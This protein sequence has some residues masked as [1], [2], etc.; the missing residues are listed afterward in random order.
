MRHRRLGFR[1]LGA[2]VLAGCVQN[3]TL[4]SQTV[5]VDPPA[6][7]TDVA[8]TPA[9]A[10]PANQ[11]VYAL[12][13]KEAQTL[14]YIKVAPGLNLTGSVLGPERLVANGAAGLIAN[15]AAGLIA[16]GAAGLIANGAA[17]LIANGAAGLIANGAAGRQTSNNQVTLDYPVADGWVALS[18]PQG[19][20]LARPDG[21]PYGGLTD[22]SGSFTLEAPAGQMVVTV[23][24]EGNRRLSA[25]VVNDR[26]DGKIAVDLGTTL[27]TEYLRSRT[28]RIGKDL[29]RVFA[30]DV[31]LVQY[32]EL[33]AQ[34][35]A[36]LRNNDLAGLTAA[37]LGLDAT[38]SMLHRYALAVGRDNS[39]LLGKAWVA[40][41]KRILGEQAPVEELMLQPLA[42]D[43]SALE[44]PVSETSRVLAFDRDAGRMYLNSYGF[45]T[46]SLIALDA[47]ATASRVV[48]RRY[49]FAANGMYDVQAIL[50]D[51]QKDSVLISGVFGD[52]LDSSYY[53]IFG[54]ARLD[55]SRTFA[56]E[57]PELAPFLRGEW[58]NASL[59]RPAFDAS[60]SV[61]PETGL[62]YFIQDLALA[63]P[64]SSGASRSLFAAD[65]GLGCVRV[66]E[67]A[68][69]GQIAGEVGLIGNGTDLPPEEREA[70]AAALPSAGTQTE[71][72]FMAPTNLCFH[73]AGGK[74]LLF[75]TDTES[76][77][78]IEVD[79][80]DNS[81]RRVAGKPAPADRSQR[82]Q[83]RKLGIDPTSMLPVDDG[84][85]AAVVALN[86]PHKVVIDTRRRMFIA[87]SDHQI[88]R[89]IRLDDPTRRIWTVAGS[90]L[91]TVIKENPGSR[92]MVERYMTQRSVN[93]R[94]G[95]S[96]VVTL[97]EVN[98]IALDGNGDLHLTD[99]RTRRVRVLRIGNRP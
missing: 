12:S 63:T 25:L 20:L 51:G 97:G 2:T 55:G 7:P 40:M 45:T 61:I 84:K 23:L 3:S 41:M 48:A 89:M 16:N 85:P 69:D 76:G 70:R 65:P 38:E 66:F 60:D 27:V 56:P 24:L 73:E 57:G 34:T 43:T 4:L 49:K 30:A 50:P 32:K 98:S 35:N 36:M 72:Y 75:V 44:A 28:R 14:G 99:D 92:A 5:I 19:A 13:D 8:T 88:I 31:G 95:E 42:L 15:G 22:A 71:L 39:G 58:Q 87:D 47:Q 54:L 80:S 37:D 79:L 9:P 59:L 6:K 17:G 94:D 10:N 91:E 74:R 46:E 62:G 96:S 26:A 67:M 52:L 81:W 29:E 53:P 82:E 78:I 68:A 86:Y 83:A 18:S 93:V 90:L 11:P 64:E 1:V 77:V 21:Q 33:V